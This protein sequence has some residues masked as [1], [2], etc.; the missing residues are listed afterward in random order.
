M[1]DCNRLNVYPRFIPVLSLRYTE[2]IRHLSQI[3]STIFFDLA[4]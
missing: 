1:A 4:S 3:L 2:L